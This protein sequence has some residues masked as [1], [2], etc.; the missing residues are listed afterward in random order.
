MAAG[1]WFENNCIYFHLKH[2]LCLLPLSFPHRV[3]NRALREG[4]E[5]RKVW[6]TLVC[7]GFSSAASVASAER[8]ALGVGSSVPRSSEVFCVLQCRQHLNPYSVVAFLCCERGG[9]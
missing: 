3:L 2:N 4:K 6:L 1:D 5:K 8:A 7:L 9:G